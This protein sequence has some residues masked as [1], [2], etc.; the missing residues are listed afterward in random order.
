MTTSLH[1]AAALPALLLLLFV[2][3]GCAYPE[4]TAADEVLGPRPISESGSGAFEASLTPFGDGLAVMWHDNRDGNDEIYARFIDADGLPRGIENRLT[5]NDEASYAR[6]TI[7]VR[8]TIR[9]DVSNYIVQ[10]INHN[11]MAWIIG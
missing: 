10:K 8:I 4:L 1:P 6:S 9:Q 5:E 3:S 11:P 2:A 7:L